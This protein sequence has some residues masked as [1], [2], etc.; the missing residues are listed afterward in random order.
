MSEP[1]RKIVLRKESPCPCG[2]GKAILNCHLDSLDGRFRKHVPSLQPPG[3]LTNYSHPDCYLR[4]TGDCSEQIS[5]EHYVSRSVLEKLGRIIA[6]S[7]A[8]WLGEGQVLETAV[9]NLTAKIL[10][11]RHNEALSPLDLEAGI[12]FEALA[13]ALIDLDRKT[14]SRKPIFHLASGEALELWLLKVACGHYFGIG[15]KDG[16]RLDRIYRIDLS[17][18]QRAFF[19]REWSARCGLYF[20]GGAGDRVTVANR[21][22]V[23][24]LLDE[25]RKEF[26]G[27]R[28]GLLGLEMD[29]LFDASNTNPGE[30]TGLAR[31]PTEFVW[32]RGVRQH[33]IILTWPPGTPERSVRIERAP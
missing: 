11:K 2:S 20:K 18:V 24:G 25:E 16:V 28:V 21:V 15:A 14:I 8:H 26:T 9:G 27:C 23:H 17:R 13:D 31:R 6:I 12:F 29:L 19:E 7:G 22:A 5:R 1:Q 32:C 33:S 30:W 4:N 3:D 10:C